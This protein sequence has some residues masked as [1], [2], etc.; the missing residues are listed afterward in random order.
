LPIIFYLSK[1][2]R[3]WWKRILWQLTFF[4]TVLTIMFTYSRGAV[5][6]LMAVLGL[7]FMR[8]KLKT[9]LMVAFV[10]LFALPLFMSFVPEQWFERMETIKTYTE[11]R[12]AMSRIEA[13]AV[14]WKL[15]LDRPLTG[16]G[17]DIINDPAMY[18][19]YDPD[20]FLRTGVH[21]VYFE[22]LAENGF[23]TLAIF[24]ALLFSCIV[25]LRK[26]RRLC[27]LNNFRRFEY[28]SH[29]LEIS[30][31]G[32]AITG[33]FLELAG[34]DLFYHVIA[35]VIVLKA[36]LHRELA[37]MQGNQAHDNVMRN[38]DSEVGPKNRTVL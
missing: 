26:M 17:F 29:M 15:A 10:F 27:R 35:M 11:D 5:L 31:Y 4:L 30:L 8:L 21:S 33:I 1:L 6:G 3:E 23:I 24:L 7:L 20:A 19:R 28:Y 25:S 9:K 38:P 37:R 18:D 34:F 32:Y 13:W 2:E 14:A 36:L 16:G 22:V 12:S